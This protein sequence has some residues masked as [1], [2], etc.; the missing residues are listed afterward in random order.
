MELQKLYAH[1]GSGMIAEEGEE[2]IETVVCQKFNLLS[3]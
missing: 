1:L 3:I 2:I